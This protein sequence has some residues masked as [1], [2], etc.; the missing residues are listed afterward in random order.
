M[1]PWLN[2]G[3][4]IRH[5]K[6]R[7]GRLPW[8]VPDLLPVIQSPFIHPPMVFM[9]VPL[10]LRILS[11]HPIAPLYTLILMHFINTCARD[12]PK[13]DIWDP[14]LRLKSKRKLVSSRLLHYPLS[15]KQ[16]R[17]NFEQLIIFPI[18][19]SQLR[20]CT[21][22]WCHRLTLTSKPTIFHVFGVRLIRSSCW[23]FDSP[24][25]ARLPVAIYPKLTAQFHHQENV[26]QLFALH[27]TM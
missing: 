27:S 26:Q 1:P 17:A 6:F 23:R 11:S 3:N 15:Q 14:S 20:R 18:H 16:L 12:S 24:Q 25:D 7:P 21:A 19:T 4:L 10:R 8:I 13:A 22:R 9:L 5:I 2:K